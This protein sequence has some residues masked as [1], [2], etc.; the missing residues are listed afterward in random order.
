MLGFGSIVE[1]ERRGEERLLSLLSTVALLFVEL[2][3]MGSFGAIEIH[4]LQ[5]NPL[6]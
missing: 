3:D 2:D 5:E 4:L 6:K 1:E